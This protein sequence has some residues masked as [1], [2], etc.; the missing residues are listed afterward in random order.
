MFWV[1][2]LPLLLPT[3]CAESISKKAQ[4]NVRT[5]APGFDFSSSQLQLPAKAGLGTLQ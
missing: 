3:V 4:T 2:F 1:K 5:A